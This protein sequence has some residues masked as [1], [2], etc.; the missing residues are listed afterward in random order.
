MVTL[1][2]NMF[3]THKCKF[4]NTQ[5]TSN[6][7]CTVLLEVF[8]PLQPNSYYTGCFTPLG[9]TAGGDFLCFCDQK[10]SYK[11]VS[12]FGRLR[13]YGFFKFPYTPSCEPRLTAGVSCTQVMDAADIIRKSELKLLSRFTTERQPVL[14]PAVAFSKT[15]FKHR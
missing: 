4:L 7:A 11:H 6:I 12:D 10:S 1:Y 2:T 5:W 13:S 15:S 14:R 8:N 9:L 3:S